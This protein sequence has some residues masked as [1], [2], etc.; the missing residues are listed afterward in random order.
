[1]G[2]E[3][4]KIMPIYCQTEDEYHYHCYFWGTLARIMDARYAPNPWL[5]DSA[6]Q[7]GP[8]ENRWAITFRNF[9][10]SAHLAV[11]WSRETG[12]NLF[13]FSDNGDHLG[14]Q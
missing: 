14:C 4:G 5:F 3:G 9:D 2:E 13:V 10:G 8:R 7:I 6:Y 12:Q 11:T 1:M